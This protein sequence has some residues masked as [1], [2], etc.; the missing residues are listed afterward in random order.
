MVETSSLTVKGVFPLLVATFVIIIKCTSKRVLKILCGPHKVSYSN[1][2]VS[3][4][5][6]HNSRV[7]IEYSNSRR[8]TRYNFI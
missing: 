6:S 1:R 3:S 5:N 7:L 8:D 4:I 2:L